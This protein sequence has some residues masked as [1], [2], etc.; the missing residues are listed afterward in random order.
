MKV[1]IKI[2][3]RLAD[4]AY[5]FLNPVFSANGKLKPQYAIVNGNAEHHPEGCYFLRHVNA[6]GK[7]IWERVMVGAP[8][9]GRG[10][11]VQDRGLRLLKVRQLEDCLRCSLLRALRRLDGLRAVAKRM[12]SVRSP[13]QFRVSRYLSRWS[14]KLYRDS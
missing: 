7:R 9:A 14:F 10:E 5:P 13:D 6:S 1:R 12:T 8:R 3:V 4:G 2:R 11:A